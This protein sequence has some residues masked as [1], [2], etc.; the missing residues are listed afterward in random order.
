MSENPKFKLFVIVILMLTGLAATLTYLF[1]SEVKPNQIAVRQEYLTGRLTVFNEQGW[2]LRSGSV[3]ELKSADILLFS[4]E[5]KATT[6]D[7]YIGVRFNDGST[8]G[9]TGSIRFLLPTNQDKILL[10]I[11]EF[12]N[13]E[14]IRKDL[15]LP[16]VRE[17][18]AQSA[19]L[20]SSDESYTTKIGLFSEYSQDQAAFGIYQTVQVTDTLT[21]SLTR[22]TKIVR[23]TEIK[24]DVTGKILR[25]NQSLTEYGI[26]LKNLTIDKI[27]YPAS[28]QQQLAAYQQTLMDIK[29]AQSVSRKEL[30][31][32]RMDREAAMHYSEAKTLRSTADA[33]A[34]RRLLMADG[35]FNRKLE[36][37]EKVMTV[38]AEAYKT[39]RPTPD[40][41]VGG[42]YGN[43]G[44]AAEQLMSI[45][46][47]RVMQELKL[48]LNPEKVPYHKMIQPEEN[49]KDETMDKK[50]E[51]PAPAKIQ[52]PKI[53]ATAKPQPIKNE[54]PQILPPRL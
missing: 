18:L 22:E 16:A 33:D 37:Y 12:G 19:A 39:Q 27:D 10:L 43:G 49:A 9:I 40:I 24:R 25:R 32:A 1:N 53:P 47:T 31:I 41:A 34:A 14:R 3:E 20:L 44:N 48:D 13:Y 42:T 6:T 23:H 50:P 38:W 29:T 45:I 26:V 30:E 21:D 17:A 15:I 54:A 5:D 28:V 35:A 7:S 2:F 8:A 52:P 51:A 11:K 46:G 36:V 4:G